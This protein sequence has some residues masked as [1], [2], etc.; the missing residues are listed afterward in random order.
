M[1]LT[2]FGQ[3]ALAQDVVMMDGNNPKDDAVSLK[4]VNG[5]TTLVDGHGHTINAHPV[6]RTDI[7]ERI[8]RGWAQRVNRGRRAF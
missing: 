8:S 1:F 3:V 2:A 5:S 6:F 4:R 7:S